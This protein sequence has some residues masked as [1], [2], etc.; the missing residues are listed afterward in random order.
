[1]SLKTWTEALQ[2]TWEELPPLFI[3]SAE[4]RVGR[5]ELLKYIGTLLSKY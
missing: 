3:T 5:E 1:M 4:K 2:E